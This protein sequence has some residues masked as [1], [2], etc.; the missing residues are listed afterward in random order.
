M[1]MA[2]VDAMMAT[3][4]LDVIAPTFTVNRL[5]TTPMRHVIRMELVVAISSTDEK[6]LRR[7]VTSVLLNS[8]ALLSVASPV[9]A[10]PGIATVRRRP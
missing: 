8:G 2:R 5:S 1:A 7:S 3:S 6:I 9:V 10:S 4:A